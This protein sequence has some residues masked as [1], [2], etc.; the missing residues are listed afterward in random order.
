MRTQYGGGRPGLAGNTMREPGSGDAAD[1]GIDVPLRA[2]RG[3]PHTRQVDP[4]E[5]GVWELAP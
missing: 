2:A 3:F 4:P 1:G 5:G